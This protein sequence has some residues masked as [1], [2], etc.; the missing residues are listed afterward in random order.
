[1]DRYEKLARFIEA[2]R[3]TPFAWGLHEN[4][5]VSFAL[6][7]LEAQGVV[8]IDRLDLPGWTT[9]LGAI[10]AV[11]A[12]AGH[13][14]ADLK[15]AV[16]FAAFLADGYKIPRGV[17]RRGDVAVWPHQDALGGQ[18]GLIYPGSGG[19]AVTPGSDGLVF[20]DLP[21]EALIWRFEVTHG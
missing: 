21:E 6:A 5:C 1:M 11:R 2:R 20:Q 13:K 8:I 16:N 14:R 17:Q 3:R 4:D 7:G 10:R 19:E 12:F 9:R 18:C 15:E